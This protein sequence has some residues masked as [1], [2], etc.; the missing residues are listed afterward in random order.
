[1]SLLG[2]FVALFPVNE[3]IS[4]R[5]I[6]SYPGISASLPQ[7]IENT[8]WPGAGLVPRGA[9]SILSQLLRR[10]FYASTRSKIG[11]GQM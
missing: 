10:L 2:K 1:M 9:L 3:H 8:W 4:L 5:L 7:Q 11:R 6:T